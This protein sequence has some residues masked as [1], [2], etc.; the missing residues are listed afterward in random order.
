MAAMK[1]C[2]ACGNKIAKSAK[3][4]PHCGAKQGGIGKI[5]GIVVIVIIVLGIIG[6]IGGGGDDEK[7]S[8][9]DNSGSSSTE[10]ASTNEESETEEEASSEADS[11][12]EETVKVGGTFEDNGLKFTVDGADLAFEITDDEYGLYNLD[13]GLHYVK[14]DFS[15]ENTGDKGDKYVSV[16]DFDCYADNSTC[17]QQYVTSVTGDFINTNLSPGRN[18]SFSTLYAVPDGAE[19]IELEYTSNVW[20]DEKVIIELQ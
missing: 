9:I 7:K 14:V 3:V 6:S 5:I 15:F 1:N 17:E 8:K 20:T 10:T 12:G 11:S 2:K 13:E 19:K 18:V 16:Y 4:C